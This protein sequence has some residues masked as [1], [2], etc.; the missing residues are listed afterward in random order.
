MK[1]EFLNRDANY[2]DIQ[3][4]IIASNFTNTNEILKSEQVLKFE[5]DIKKGNVDVITNDD[6]KEDYDNKYYTAKDVSKFEGELDALINKG[7][8][9]F[10]TDEEYESLEKGRADIDGLERKAVAFRKGEVDGYVEI[11][12]SSKPEGEEEGEGNDE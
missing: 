9:D 8:T 11:F 12:V 1:A 2:E 7:E 3:K 6:L 5:E 4:G 10:L